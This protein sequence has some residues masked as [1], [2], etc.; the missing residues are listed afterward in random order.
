M[1]LS[2]DWEKAQERPDKTQKVEGRFLLD[3]RTK[4]NNLYSISFTFFGFM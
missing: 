2:I 3:F 1:K 4:V